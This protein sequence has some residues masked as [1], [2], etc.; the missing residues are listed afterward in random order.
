MDKVE[1]SEHSNN[2][3]GL[4]RVSAMKAFVK[5][6]RRGFTGKFWQKIR[7]YSEYEAC[8]DLIQMARVDVSPQCKVLPNGKRLEIKQHEV[9]ASLR[10]LAKR[11][12]W[13]ENKVK[14]FL[15]EL[16][17]AH[18][19]AHRT[20]HGETILNLENFSIYEDCQPRDGTVNGTVNGT[21][22]AQW[23]HSDG[24]NI[25][26][27]ENVENV[28][29]GENPPLP[30]ERG[31]SLRDLGINPRALGT[32]PRAEGINPR[33]QGTNPRAEPDVFLERFAL[34]WKAYPRKKGT[35]K[36]RV[37]F[38]KL[39]PSQELTERM[40]RAVELEKQSDKWQRDNG[41]YIPNPATW[42]NGGCWDDEI[43][44]TKGGAAGEQRFSAGQ[45]QKQTGFNPAGN[46][47]LHSA[48]DDIPD[49]NE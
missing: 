28:E 34:F 8:I 43:I 49:N 37:A 18:Y 47:G 7:T 15:Q 24:T 31:D 45:E 29:N 3:G 27:G 42:L 17:I 1:T 48:L 39:K 44:T 25:K 33:E 40:I 20:A 30:R 12:Q 5:V 2:L 11:W 14:R 36:A 23:R 38:L 32:N 9:H 46:R 21:P 22:A 13:S 4:K 19:L 10:F 35:D 6:D 16:R 41:Q 26:N